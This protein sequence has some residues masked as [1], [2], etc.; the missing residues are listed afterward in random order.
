[1]LRE[2]TPV[3]KE[4]N[5]FNINEFLNLLIA[6]SQ[7]FLPQIRCMLKLMPLKTS[8]DISDQHQES[9]SLSVIPKFVYSENS[10][11]FLLYLLSSRDIHFLSLD[12]ESFD[13]VLNAFCKG[14][15]NF[16]SKYDSTNIK[17]PVSVLVTPFQFIKYLHDL[18]KLFF[19]LYLNS[20]EFTGLKNALNPYIKFF[21]ISK[22]RDDFVFPVSVLKKEILNKEFMNSLPGNELNKVIFSAI[23]FGNLVD[24][25]KTV[26]YKLQTK[27]IS[28][29]TASKI[30]FFNTEL[31]FKEIFLFRKLLSQ[32]WFYLSKFKNLDYDA[33]FNI[34]QTRILMLLD[35]FIST[36]LSLSL[37]IYYKT[38][39]LNRFQLLFDLLENTK[40]YGYKISTDPN[41]I[42]QVSR[43]PFY[44]SAFLRDSLNQ[45]LPD[46]VLKKPYGHLRIKLIKASLVT[47][48]EFEFLPPFIQELFKSF[49]SI[50][51]IAVTLLRNTGIKL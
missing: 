35:L 40:N 41:Y 24:Y 14:L 29:K 27:A 22:P 39:L 25:F 13:T 23:N 4:A 43:P 8:S 10:V 19:V 9:D 51:K 38:I 12:L 47:D 33:L 42:S 32:N 15:C 49:D 11:A 1:M 50:Y 45:N 20:N 3:W 48:N 36:F 44:K 2:L 34:L 7:D 46:S 37:P 18:K 17:N 16:C 28:P 6:Q 21:V 26:L 5:S 30:V 31:A